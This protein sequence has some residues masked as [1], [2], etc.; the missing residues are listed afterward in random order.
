MGL[1]RR[2]IVERV[3]ALTPLLR[4]HR[5]HSEVHARPAPEVVAACQDAGLFVMGAPAEA[6]GL[7]VPFADQF[8]ATALVAEV[9]PGVAWMMNN[10]VG[11]SRLASRMEPDDVQLVFEPPYGP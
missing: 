4:E 2:E 1:A 9:D 6:A 8:E 7:E 11:L 3:Q 10:S 5:E